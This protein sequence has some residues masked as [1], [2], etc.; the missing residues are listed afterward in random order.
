M[1]N[2][3]DHAE[4]HQASEHQPSEGVSATPAPQPVGHGHEPE[5]DPATAAKELSDMKLVVL[6]SAEL[7]NRSANKAAETGTEFKLATHDLQQM[8]QR[9]RKFQTILMSITGGL[10]VVFAVMFA[11]ITFTLKARIHQ[12]DEMLSATSSKIRELNEGLEVV[13]S[14]NEGFQ[15]MVTKQ[16]NMAAAQARLEVSLSEMV[17]SNQ[18][19][20]QEK[21]KQAEAREQALN[22]Q[23]TAL[24]NGLKS[25][26]QAIGALATQMQGLRQSMG[27]AG[28]IKRDMEA[29][30]KIQRERQAAE[31]NS[32]STVSKAKPNPEP[33]PER[34]KERFVRYPRPE[35]LGNPAQGSGVLSTQ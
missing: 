30:V 1:S 33:V 26:S 15:E 18:H 13:G 24:E 3:P 28:Q 5:L 16:A 8:M 4:Q 22:K 14:V 11:T 10:L 21:A 2:A 32:S 7:A 25:Q 12:M 35:T 23:V 17:Q 27:D 31:A 9:Q 29:L 20:P 34:P 19:V 6:E